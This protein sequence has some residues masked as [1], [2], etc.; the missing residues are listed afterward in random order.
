MVK[1]HFLV[2]SAEHGL[3]AGEQVWFDIARA[4]KLVE[5]K[6]AEAIDG[7]AIAPHSAA[8]VDEAPKPPVAPADSAPK[9]K[10]K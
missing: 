7:D 1:L 4:A 9:K 10:A 3:H 5:A 6:V 8:K 2:D